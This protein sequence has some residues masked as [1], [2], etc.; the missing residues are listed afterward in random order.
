MENFK[1]LF[2]LTKLPTKFFILFSFL[3]GFLLFAKSEILLKFHLDNLIE[4]HGWIIGLVFIISTGLVIV[5]FIVWLFDKVTRKIK[6]EKLI[7]Q[8]KKS[9]K[10]LDLQEKSVLRE[11][12]INGQFSIEMPIDNPIVSGL[13]K[14]GILN[15]NRQFG[16]GFIMTGSNASI[17][18]NP[19]A[20]KVLTNDDLGIPDNPTET[21]KQFIFQNRPNWA[22]RWK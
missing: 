20:E 6:R 15:L 1:A 11:F 7:K 5:N 10:N 9:L 13:I 12:I 4:K 21:D 19:I 22:K 17:S 14:K 3:S 18:L 8:F 2:D 16:N